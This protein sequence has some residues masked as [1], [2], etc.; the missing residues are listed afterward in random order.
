MVL[1]VVAG[2]RALFLQRPRLLDGAIRGNPLLDHNNT[3]KRRDAVYL[4]GVLGYLLLR[5]AGLQL[6]VLPGVQ[7]RAPGAGEHADAAVRSSIFLAKRV[8]TLMLCP[9]LTCQ[10]K[11]IIDISYGT[12]Q[13]KLGPLLQTHRPQRP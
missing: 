1:R 9:Y 3:D 5:A 8:E 11:S 12:N 4:L 10:A 2:A 6:R 13:I 7:G